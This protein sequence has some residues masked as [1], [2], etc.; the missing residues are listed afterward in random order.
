MAFNN[1]LETIGNT[2]LVKI[3][4]IESR[5]QVWAKVE[6]FNPGG[7]IKDRI[8]LSMIETA[9]KEGKIEPKK[10]TII[11][12]TSGNTGIG[13]AIVCAVKGYRLILTMPESMSMERRKLLHALG[14]EIKL[15]PAQKGMK[16]SISQAESLADSIKPSFIPQQ[17]KNPANPGIHFKAT[18]A[19]IWEQSKG[20]I[21]MLV[22]GV[23]TG[24]TI[25]GCSQYLKQK[26]PNLVSVA[27]EPFSSSVLSGFKPGPH[28][29][30]GIGAGFV[31]PVLDT[32]I[33]DRIVR[34]EE[35]DA[36]AAARKLAWKEGILAGISSGAALWAA[37]QL[38]EAGKE[39]IK[40]I[41]VVLPDGGER[42]MSTGLFG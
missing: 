39:N 3:N 7:S 1:I 40:N 42:Y 30:Q 26:N 22:C 6:A 23:G 2:P 20:L 35:D 24:G 14:A 31:P 17:F 12:P 25:T 15:T 21:D 10:S 11:E 36:V 37:T 41:V 19:E 18:G 13:L 8:A 16:G 32:G 4:H 27:V 28:K 5:I 9:E 34:V 38:A 33:I 29:I